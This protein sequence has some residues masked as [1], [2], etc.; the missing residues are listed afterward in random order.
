VLGWRTEGVPSPYRFA[1]CFYPDRG[2]PAPWIVPA[3]PG[4]DFVPRRVPIEVA[5]AT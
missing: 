1:H 4:A 3:V 5:L 2:S